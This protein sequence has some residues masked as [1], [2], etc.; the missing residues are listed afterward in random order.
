MARLERA[1]TRDE[2]AERMAGTTF[3]GTDM[4]DPEVIPFFTWDAPLSVR[5]IRQRQ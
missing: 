2:V 1:L 5:E 3:L 4:S